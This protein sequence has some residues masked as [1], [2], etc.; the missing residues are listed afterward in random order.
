MLIISSIQSVQNQKKGYSLPV[1]IYLLLH[2]LNQFAS[3]AS[4]VHIHIQPQAKTGF[5]RSFI[6]SHPYPSL[7]VSI[8]F[9]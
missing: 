9:C 8:H 1:H 5:H 2:S 4:P 3:P 7:I 6:S